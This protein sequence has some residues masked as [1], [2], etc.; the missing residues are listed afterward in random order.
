MSGY[1]FRWIAAALVCTVATAELPEDNWPTWRGPNADGVALKGAP[2][3]SWSETKN[4]KWKVAIEG[5]SSSTPVVWGDK[6]FIQ[7][8]VPTVPQASAEEPSRPSRRGRPQNVRAPEDPYHFNVLCIDKKTGKTIWSETATTATPHEGHHATGSFAPFSPVT[9]GEKLWVSFG[10]QGL[11]CYDLDGNKLWSQDLIEMRTRNGFGEGS[12]PAIVGDVVAVLMDQEG[13]SMIAAFNKDTGNPIW[14]EP[15]SEVTSWTTPLGIVV[16]E[17]PQF[18]TS[19]TERIRSYDANTGK[20]LWE[21]S[22]LTTNAIPSPVSDGTFVYCTSGFR[23]FAL[24]AIELGHTGD[25]TGTDAIKWEV[26]R[27]TP[28]VA[29]PVLYEGYIYV[30]SNLRPVLSCFDAKTGEAIF[31]EKVLEGLKQIYASPVAANGYIYVADREGAVAVLK[32]GKTFAP[33]A[34]NSLDEGFDAS[35]IVV[36]D[37]MYMKGHQHLYCIASE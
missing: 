27:G 15:R 20:I 36:G 31:E 13:D 10:S 37:T 25:L 32:H 23:G 1:S 24:K 8:A 16:D 5:E 6:L 28:Y 3:T 35:P 29:S 17:T 22:G 14:R 34:V 9:D 21:C 4:V 26:D 12:S 33:I 18:I 19:A 30:L 2:P 11:Y 7:T